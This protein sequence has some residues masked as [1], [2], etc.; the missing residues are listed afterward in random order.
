M[1]PVIIKVR[2]ELSEL[3]LEVNGIPIHRDNGVDECLR[4]PF[5]T[6]RSLPDTPKQPP[7]LSFRER[8]MKAEEGIGTDDD[9]VLDDSCGLDD[10]AA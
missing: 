7:V 10:E 4:W 5:G 2:L 6:R 8:C 3:A 9:G 1:R